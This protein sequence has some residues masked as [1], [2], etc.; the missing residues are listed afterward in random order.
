MKIDL[1]VVGKL[2]DKNLQAIE[3]EYTKRLPQGMFLIH[4]VKAH[5]D[6]ISQ[7]HLAIEKKI[8][9]LKKP[10]SKIYALT[11][12]GEH[13]SSLEF[14]K[15]FFRQDHIHIICVIAG[16]HG[17][18]EDFLKNVN[19]KVSLSKLTFPHRIARILFI[20]QIYRAYTIDK[21]HPYHN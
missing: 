12:W 10:H 17:H 11:E 13:F 5:S 6:Q 3:A 8:L 4:E 15:L 1:I 9:S 18:S 16:A 19:K 2:K 21:G 14:S 20:E 7:E